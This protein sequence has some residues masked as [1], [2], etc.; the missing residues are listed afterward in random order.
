MTT[1]RVNQTSAALPALLRHIL[2]IT[3]VLAGLALPLQSSAVESDAGAGKVIFVFGEAWKH[4][5]DG[6][7]HNL[8][9]GMVVNVGETIE[10]SSTGQVQIRMNDNGLISIRPS[11]QFKIKAFQFS[12]ATGA[13]SADDKS[14]F[15]LLKG[16]FRSI[17]GAVGQNNKKAYKVITPVATI[18]IRGTDYSARLCDGDCAQGDGLYVGVWRG[19]V[20]LSNDAGVLNVDAGQ[21][22]YVPDLGSAGQRV[23]SLPAGMLVASSGI[24]AA[25][26]TGEDAATTIAELAAND[27]ALIEPA[28]LS[29]PTTGTASYNLAS[30][31]GS[32]ST[33]G[34]A[35]DSNLSTATLN[36]NF[37]AMSVDASVDLNFT[38]SAHWTGSATGMAL[39]GNGGFSG[40]MSTV[41][42]DS[43]LPETSLTSSGSFNGSLTGLGEGTV[44]TGAD[45]NFTMDA[46]FLSTGAES[47]SGQ[48]AFAQ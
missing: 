28:V 21:F 4:T 32:N 25:T 36:A 47:V 29:L 26:A 14:Y 41:T 13:D 1:K 16:G 6:G 17:T 44:P 5:V 39:Q 23:D 22:G 8:K 31:S 40:A 20:S 43:S 27:I 2:L 11:S 3:L 30:M 24:K 19:G 18:G 34:A 48:A 15:Q 38:D 35:I 12:G 9:R 33:T 45:L 37:T 10:T 7:K 42:A 46:N